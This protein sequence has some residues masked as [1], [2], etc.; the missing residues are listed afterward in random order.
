MYCHLIGKAFR[1]AGNSSPLPHSV[2]GQTTAA[3]EVLCVRF[4]TPLGLQYGFHESSMEVDPT[5][6]MKDLTSN[7]IISQY[8]TTDSNV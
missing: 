3:S 2:Q 5:R 8:I 7:E 6:N 4:S 1:E